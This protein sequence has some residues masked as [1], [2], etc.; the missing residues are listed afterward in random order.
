MK[1]LNDRELATILAGLRLFQRRR[2]EGSAFHFENDVRPLNDEEIDA[3]CEELNCRDAGDSEIDDCNVTIAERRGWYAFNRVLGHPAGPVA[4]TIIVTAVA[5]GQEGGSAL[6]D[7]PAGGTV[8]LYWGGGTEIFHLDGVRAASDVT[9]TGDRTL[10]FTC[11]KEVLFLARLYEEQK[12]G[13]VVC[14]RIR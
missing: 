2:K 1:D 6:L 5:P 8:T 7:I 4:D 3:L 13:Q 9:R 12:V 14:E 11:G 10:A